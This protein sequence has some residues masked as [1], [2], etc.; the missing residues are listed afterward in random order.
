MKYPVEVPYPPAIFVSS[1][2]GKTYAVGGKWVEIPD[3]TTREELHKYVIHKKP[4]Y[5]VREWKVASSSG[6]KY[7]VRRI[8]GDRFTCTCPGFKFRRKCKH[9]EQVR[10]K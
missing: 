5:D 7:T 4:K 6:S 2:S 10:S 9:T 8:N 1:V 3:G